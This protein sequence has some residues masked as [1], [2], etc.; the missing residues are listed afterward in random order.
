M[1]TLEHRSGSRRAT[2]PS[3]PGAT[4]AL[5]YG[6]ATFGGAFGFIAATGLAATT[7]ANDNGALAVG[8]LLALYQVSA[9]LAAPYA[10]RLC[11]DAS[12]RL[13]FARVQGVSALVWLCAGVVL[14]V[15]GPSL[16]V[17]MVAAVPV[18]FGN[19]LMTV[20]RPILAKSYLG[21]EHTSGAVA[22]MSMVIGV[23]WG[24]GALVAGW[25]LSTA[26][27]GWGLIIYG[28]SA[29][30]LAVTVRTVE[31]RVE[32]AEVL[33]TTQPWRTAWERLQGNHVV[34]WS[35]VV[36][37]AGALF[38][39]PFAGLVVPIANEFRAG[40]P[41]S[42][43]G[44]L[45][46]SIAVG[47]LC[48]PVVVRRLAAHR[49]ELWAAACSTALCGGGLIMLAV[50]SALMVDVVG[51]LAVWLVIGVAFGATRFGAQALYFGAAAESGPAEDAPANLAAVTLST[52]LLGPLG[53]IASSAV[54]GAT[55]A[56]VTV[57]A[58]GVGAVAVGAFVAV[59]ASTTP[60]ER[61][62]GEFAPTG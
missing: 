41:I 10:P 1:S 50:V 46:A 33:A 62:G 12:V 8:A 25:F 7:G 29:L 21:H 55:S 54:L 59:T 43:A 39:A 24:V 32:A 52:L 18:G 14:V 48:S 30:G 49:T 20:F 60:G 15:S 4:Y 9:A 26:A 19:G 5:A 13:V 44:F 61:R 23:T 40:R 42:G 35:A 51:E 27:L 36:G 17:L 45:M 56:Y 28:V 37:V 6:A 34:R 31:P 3:G 2:L 47:Q 22:S 38:L 11:R 53:V 16:A 58:A 57:V